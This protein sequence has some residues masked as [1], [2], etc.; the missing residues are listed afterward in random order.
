MKNLRK[1]CVRFSTERWKRPPSRLA[2]QKAFQFK[3]SIT[4][5][6]VTMREQGIIVLVF[7]HDRSDLE[8][9][10]VSVAFFKARGDWGS[11]DYEVLPSLPSYYSL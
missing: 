8:R 1:V 7:H 2:A 11:G 6:P 5:Q 10:S 3:A 4:C 9:S